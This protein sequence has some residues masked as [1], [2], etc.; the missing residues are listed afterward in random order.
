[1]SSTAALCD[2]V[3]RTI[4]DYEEKIAPING[5]SP[6]EVLQLLVSEHGLKQSDFNEILPQSDLSAVLR[7]KRSLTPKQISQLSARFNVS[8]A[9]FIPIGSVVS[10]RAKRKAA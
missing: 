2:I 8:P 10:S 7:G 5:S 9:G 6:A 1:M 3:G 4:E